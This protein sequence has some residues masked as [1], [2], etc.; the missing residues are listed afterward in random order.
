MPLA[1][2]SGSLIVK[3]GNIAENC[4]CCGGWYCHVGQCVN[5]FSGGTTYKL[6]GSTVPFVGDVYGWSE[7]HPHPSLETVTIS[8]FFQRIEILSPCKFYL[9]I[10]IEVSAAVGGY[11]TFFWSPAFNANDYGIGGPVSDSISDGTVGARPQE[12]GSSV[13]GTYNNPLWSA[14]WAS[15]GTPAFSFEMTFNEIADARCVP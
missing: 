14:K 9:K 13:T 7:S 12:N 15:Y 6:N 10:S 2:K 3:D 11:K 5:A 8:G 4:G 1:T